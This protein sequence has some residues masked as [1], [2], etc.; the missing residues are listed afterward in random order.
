MVV[1]NTPILNLKVFTINQLYKH[2]FVDVQACYIG[3]MHSAS[4]I[5]LVISVMN[6]CD[7]MNTVIAGLIKTV[8]VFAV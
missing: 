1:H 3:P 5:L 4:S 7:V 8:F 2:C 6:G